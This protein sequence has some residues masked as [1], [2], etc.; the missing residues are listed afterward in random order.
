MLRCWDGD[1]EEG[2][3]LEEEIQQRINVAKGTLG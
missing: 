3:D 2:N 1:V